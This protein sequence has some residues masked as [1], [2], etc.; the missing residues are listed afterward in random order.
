MNDAKCNPLEIKDGELAVFSHSNV[1]KDVW[2]LPVLP[3]KVETEP[4][5]GKYLSDTN[6]LIAFRRSYQYISLK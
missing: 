4:D 1:K 3:N 6:K 5:S 2:M